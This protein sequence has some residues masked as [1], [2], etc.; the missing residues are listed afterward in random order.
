M[1]EP[2]TG[3]GNGETDNED[4][5]ATE[6]TQAR[7]RMADAIAE[8]RREGKKAAFIY[9]VVDGV[10][11]FLAANVLLTVL[12]PTELPTQVSVPTAVTERI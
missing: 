11:L 12:E 7:E 2:D 3:T 4:P 8:V 9:A 6:R 10:L 1:D 5:S